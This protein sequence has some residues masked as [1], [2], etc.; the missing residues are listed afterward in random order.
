MDFDS[1]ICRGALVGGLFLLTICSGLGQ[2]VS[3][4]AVRVSAAV[5]SHPPRITLSWPGDPHATAYTVRRKSR[6]EADWGPGTAMSGTATSYVDDNVSVGTAYEYHIQKAAQSTA[7]YEGHGY[8]YAGIELPFVE[9]RGKVILL[10]ENTFASSLASEL[11]LLQRDLVGDGWTVV[12]HDL[13]RMSVDPA[14]LS[15]T[16]WTAR[17]KELSQIKALVQAEY[18]ADPAHV[19]A[20]FLLGHLPVPYSGM[21]APDGHGDHVGAWPAMVYYAD[22]DGAWTDGT[23]NYSRAASPRNRNVPGDGKFDNSSLPSDAELMI[24]WVDMANLPAFSQSEGE[25]LRRYLTKDHKFRHKLVTAEPRG[26]IEDTG[27]L[28]NGEAPAVNGWRNFAPFFGAANTIAGDWLSTLATESYLFG[29]GG[30]RGTYTSVW[31]VATTAELANSDPKVVF[32]LFFGSYHA[33]WDSPDNVMRAALATPTYTLTT[34]WTGRPHWPLHHMALGEPIGF[35]ARLAQNNRG[36]YDGNYRLH[37]VHIGLLGDPTLRMH[38]VAPPAS[39]TATRNLSGGVDLTWNASLDTVLGYHVYR[40]SSATGRYARINSELVADT[41]H[42]DPAPGNE[43]FYMVRAVKLEVSGSGSYFN[44]SQGIF[45]NLDDALIPTT[46]LV[47]SS[48]N[49]AVPGQAVTF[50]AALTALPPAAQ[51]PA[52]A[53]RFII[54]GADAS[55]PVPLERG[56]ASY[57]PPSLGHGTHRVVAEYAGDGTFAGATRALEPDQ[58]INTPPLAGPDT[59]DRE[60]ASPVKVS[61]A[62]LLKNDSDADGDAISALDVSATSAMGATVTRRDDWVFYSS[63]LSFEDPDTFTYTITDGLGPPVTGVVTVHLRGNNGPSPNL[64]ITQLGDGSFQVRGDGIPDRSYRIQS[65][66]SLTNPDWQ[67]IGTVTADHFGVF[68]Y[69]DQIGLIGGFYRS[70]SP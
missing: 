66:D 9:H 35:S 53:V 29:F 2:S 49:P 17:A 56:F 54:D 59:I 55:G 46:A 68:V 38:P 37:T 18:E 10:I 24:G 48:A 45:Q 39:L 34:A 60:G 22:V 19:K 61:I 57:S 5:Q 47:A 36:L 33:D 26:L 50:T 70:V 40:A 8:I 69:A 58:V 63:A 15:S 27:G 7:S 64:T 43:R 42:S 21:I 52:G 51:P 11:L 20:V 67:T 1:R 28:L 32:T 65:A 62:K 23:I 14:D 4:Y 44:A 31:E 13:P 12:R 30:G 3:D 6:D 41:N 25:L 16:V